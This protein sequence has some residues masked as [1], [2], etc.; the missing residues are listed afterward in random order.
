[1]PNVNTPEKMP[2]HHL[3]QPT[4]YEQTKNSHL[5]LHKQQKR[6]TQ[7][8]TKA[9]DTLMEQHT[10]IHSDV[11]SKVLSTILELSPDK[12]SNTT[13]PSCA[14]GDPMAMLQSRHPTIE[15]TVLAKIV[16]TIL[17]VPAKGMLGKRSAATDLSPGS[18][19]ASTSANN[20][21]ALL[22]GNTS[23]DVVDPATLTEMTQS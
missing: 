15:A 19:V 7:V 21:Y 14:N 1:M 13:D 11:L 8:D 18:K 16:S 23:L 10:D 6:M 20:Q 5:P 9:M 3:S 22:D 4:W 12:E 2:E 17:S